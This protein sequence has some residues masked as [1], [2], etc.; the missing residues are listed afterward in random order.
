LKDAHVGRALRLLHADPQR[1]WTVDELAR[2]VA[3]SRSVLAQRFTELVGEAPMRYL[4]NWRMQ[5][6][7][8]MIRD[9]ARNIQDIASRV[10]Y[11]SEAAFNRAFK[12]RFEKPP[13][14]YRRD[15]RERPVPKTQRVAKSA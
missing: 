14:R 4:M 2:E 6:A 5:L 12:R 11:E 1:S 15:W 3:V 9:G 8:Q 10:G 13:A 7:R